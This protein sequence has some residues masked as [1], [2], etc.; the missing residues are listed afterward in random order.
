ML[1][2]MMHAHCITSVRFCDMYNADDTGCDSISDTRF[3]S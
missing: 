3:T 2:S 1:F